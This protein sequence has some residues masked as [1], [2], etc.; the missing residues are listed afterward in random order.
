M[1]TCSHCNKPKPDVKNYIIA[2]DL[3]HPRP[4]C[5]ECH[6]KLIIETMITIGEMKWNENK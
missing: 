5:D 1:K 2:D 4:M 6:R 3:E